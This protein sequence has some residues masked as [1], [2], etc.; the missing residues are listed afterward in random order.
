MS[1]TKAGMGAQT[2]EHLPRRRRGV[3]QLVR[4]GGDD[5]PFL[6]PATPDTLAVHANGPL[7]RFAAAGVSGAILAVLWCDSCT[8][9]ANLGQERRNTSPE[10]D[11][12]RGLPRSRHEISA[13]RLTIDPR[14]WQNREWCGIR[15]AISK[16]QDSASCAT[17]VPPR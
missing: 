5:A 12:G 11:A 10:G 3:R 15:I 16:S 13:S 6:P 2:R 8:I 9:A 7:W 17:P 1:Q 4:K 14:L